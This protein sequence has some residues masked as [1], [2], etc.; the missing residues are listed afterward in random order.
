MSAGRPLLKLFLFPLTDQLISSPLCG[1][2]TSWPHPA[3]RTGAPS[4]LKSQDGSFSLGQNMSRGGQLSRACVI[5]P[6]QSS[7]KWF[8]TVVWLPSTS[9]RVGL[10][11]ID[12]ISSLF[13]WCQVH[14]SSF[15]TGHRF[16]GLP[17]A[18][19]LTVTFCLGQLVC[20]DHY[21]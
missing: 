3:D 13:H 12:Y 19:P 8:L 4:N 10:T 6:S 11:S 5:L 14:C 18:D 16:T 20:I 7:S 21:L 2:S 15:P 9:Q 17:T 1:R